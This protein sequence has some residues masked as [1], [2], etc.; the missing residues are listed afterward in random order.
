[1]SNDSQKEIAFLGIKV[2]SSSVREP[3]GNGATERFIRPLR[4]SLLLDPDFETIERLRPLVL[5]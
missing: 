1:M 3:Y 5:R 4:A 2:L